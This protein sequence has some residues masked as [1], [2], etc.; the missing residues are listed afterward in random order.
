MKKRTDC[1]SCHDGEEKH[2]WPQGP[3]YGAM[4][5]GG[6]W[7][8]TDSVDAEVGVSLSRY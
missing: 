2:R 6:F 4:S 1:D 5:P 7:L 8:S 3:A